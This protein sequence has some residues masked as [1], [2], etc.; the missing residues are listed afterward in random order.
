MAERKPLSDFGKLL[1]TPKPGR[2]RLT[3]EAIAPVG[4][5]NLAHV[6]IAAR[7]HREPCGEMN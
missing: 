4:K 7:I 3:L 5:R 6:D 1:Q 2:M